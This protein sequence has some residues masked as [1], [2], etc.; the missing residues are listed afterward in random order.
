MKVS[1]FKPSPGY[2]VTKQ[3]A[4]EVTSKSGFVTNENTDDFLVNG[5]VV[6]SADSRY[7]IKD[8]VVFH[9]IDVESFRDG[10]DTYYLV[11]AD[12]IRGTYGTQE[13]APAAK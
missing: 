7:N 8:V 5:Q 11:H 12:N 2:L 4:E 3:E 1:A 13:D 9:V 10:S 6:S